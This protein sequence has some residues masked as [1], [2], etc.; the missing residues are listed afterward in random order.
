MAA[1]HGLKND[2]LDLILHSP[3]GSLDAADQIV[4]YL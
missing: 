2:K 3:G 1:L 4:Q